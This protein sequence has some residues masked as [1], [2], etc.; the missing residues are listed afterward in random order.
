LSSVFDSS[1]IPDATLAWFLPFLFQV[2]ESKYWP[3]FFPF[4]V[5]SFLPFH[6]F[7]CES[8]AA[9]LTLGAAPSSSLRW[10][11]IFSS[12]PFNCMIS[13]L[14]DLFIPFFLSQRPPLFFSPRWAPQ[15]QTS[16]AL[17]ASRD[18]FFPL[19]HFEESS[20]FFSQL[21]CIGP[22]QPGRK[23]SSLHSPLFHI[24]ILLLQGR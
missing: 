22:P 23:K 4:L 3:S 19:S 1:L 24:G 7:S 5:F 21:A 17:S 20:A 12:P 11:I 6:S 15:I 13:F 10:L 14:F 16:P 18:F 9:A 8:G 2:E